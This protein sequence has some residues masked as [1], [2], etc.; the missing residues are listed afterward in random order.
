MAGGW[1]FQTSSEAYDIEGHLSFQRAPIV[2]I[3]KQHAKEIRASDIVFL[4]RSVKRGR[5]RSFVFA[6]GLTV[7]EP[8]PLHEFPRV[9]DFWK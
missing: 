6:R 2:W 9:P 4:W 5:Q 3:V 8:R 1:I 7:S